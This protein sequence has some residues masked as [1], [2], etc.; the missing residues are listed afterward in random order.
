[1]GRHIR[2]DTPMTPLLT[3]R[4]FTLLSV[5]G[6]VGGVGYGLTAA[7]RR[8]RDTAARLSSQ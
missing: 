2:G 8:V 4:R 5:A 6:V 3:R 1:M 7:V